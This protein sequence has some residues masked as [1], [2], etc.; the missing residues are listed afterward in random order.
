M[1]QVLKNDRRDPSMAFRMT[2][3]CEY[4]LHSN[5]NVKIALMISVP[6]LC[7]QIRMSAECVQVAPS[8]RSNYPADS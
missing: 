1:F 8:I 7:D 5:A 3:C 2:G 6:P 4:Q